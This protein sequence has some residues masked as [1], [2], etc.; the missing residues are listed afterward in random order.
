[1]LQA[2]KMKF[3]VRKDEIIG[4]KVFKFPCLGYIIKILTNIFYII[5][6]IIILATIYLYN[7]RKNKKKMIRRKK[8]RLEDEKKDC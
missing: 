2:L 8:K 6:I 1:V 7:K 3:T 4:I 5:V